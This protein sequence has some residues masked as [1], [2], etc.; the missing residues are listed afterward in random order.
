MPAIDVFIHEPTTYSAAAAPNRLT[1]KSID[2]D[3]LLER[4]NKLL[5]GLNPGKIF[6]NGLPGAE[7]ESVTINVGISVQ[8]GITVV[9]LA[10]VGVDASISVTLRP[11]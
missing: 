3:D 2:G 9:A 10:T 6:G 5:A 8:G 7:V 11:K 1:K 4:L